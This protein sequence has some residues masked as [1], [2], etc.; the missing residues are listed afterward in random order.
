[1][2]KKALSNIF[3]VCMVYTVLL[4]VTL[5]ALFLLAASNEIQ[6][7]FEKET[8]FIRSEFEKINTQNA[9]LSGD[10]FSDEYVK[11]Y[12]VYGD[13][14]AKHKFQT[15]FG[16]YAN[17]VAPAIESIAV[18]KMGDDGFY[19]SN[20]AKTVN[21]YADGI[22]ITKEKLF[23]KLENIKS[24]NKYKATDYFVAGNTLTAITYDG[25][26]Y[27]D[28]FL[29]VTFN[30]GNIFS[31]A[32][33]EGKD[34]FLFRDGAAIYGTSDNLYRAAQ[35]ALEGKNSFFYKKALLDVSVAEN[36]DLLQIVCIA[37]K[38]IYAKTY[39]T[40][41]L[42]AILISVLILII[43]IYVMRK[44]A[45]GIYKPVK[46]LLNIIGDM[47]DAI[48]D[49]FETIGK[50]IDN[51]KDEN[52]SA[53]ER[54]KEKES[55]LETQFLS[56]V[57]LGDADMDDIPGYIEKNQLKSKKMNVVI[58]K[59]ID[60]DLVYSSL[61]EMQFYS[62]KDVIKKLLN[63]K[64]S[65]YD[66]ARIINLLPDGHVI[67]YSGELNGDFE[68]DITE[69]IN[70]VDK[71][72]SVN[73][74]AYVGDAV[75]SL[76]ELCKSYN[77]AL[78]ISKCTTFQGIYRPIY[79]KQ[80][81][82]EIQHDN[83][84]YPIEI[85]TALIS[86]VMSGNKEAVKDNVSFLVAMNAATSHQHDRFVQLVTMFSATVSRILSELNIDVEQVLGEGASIYLE[87]RQADNFANLTMAV[88]DILEKIVEH[89]SKISIEEYKSVQE[90]IEEYIEN[91]YTRDISLSD[92]AEYLKLSET[93]VSKLF[94]KSM[95][96]NFKEY[97]MY[98]KYTKAKQIMK[99]NPT[100]KL[101]D[102]A[103][104][105]GCNTPLTLSRLLKKY[106]KG[107]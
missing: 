93:Y 26:K 3:Y 25:A 97:L 2:Y 4:S 101:K 107:E 65:G 80:T 71:K 5:S 87:L 76:H 9:I 85:E 47:P 35:A 106:D 60:C 68:R 30:I 79:S 48:E 74:C 51:L 92:L 70:I 15:E 100:Y 54:I 50:F 31:D 52:N 28:F 38:T 77:D 104:M 8:S 66:Y 46:G 96:K 49:E 98:Y 20:G 37:P 84:M 29:L 99:E 59:Y 27:E 44:I 14:Y 105:I 56:S 6:S 45:E 33:S 75:D 63:E 88:V 78:Y 55:L 82:L 86:A 7:S 81:L 89:S 42:L 41:A 11:K 91:N 57:L 58:L 12:V 34:I 13:I 83:F 18:F 64:L 102:V 62:L 69:V 19:S 73:L 67:I 32:V 39:L 53:Q 36:G 16:K 95:G 94:K 22:G 10:V 40:P 43:G 72:F 103:E 61:S 1:M 90:S 23:E 21:Y 24:L 17:F